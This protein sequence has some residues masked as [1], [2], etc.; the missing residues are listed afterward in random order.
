MT[1]VTETSLAAA[2]AAGGPLLAGQTVILT[3]ASGGIGAA[4]A[5]LLV[6]AGAR[7]A[8]TDL[9]AQPLA[10]LAGELRERTAAAAARTADGDGSAGAEE[11]L[12]AA[13]V[14]A[15]DH[16]AFAA[17]HA[18]TEA[19]LGPVDG[20]VN[21]AGLFEVRS[22]DQLDPAAWSRVVAANLMTAAAGCAAVL[23]G[24]IA[25]G[26]GSVV[27][28]ASTA[29]EYGSISPAAH[30][31]AAKGGVIGLTK[32]LAR[33]AAPAQVRVN[34]VSPGPTETAGLR[35]ATPD[36]RALA[37]SRT[38]FGRLGQPEEIAGACLFLLSP[39]STFVTGHVLR[40]NGGALL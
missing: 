2:L 6:A 10:E 12:F 34:A 40:V 4:I 23:P 33:E 16:A 18:D 22:H 11:R 32:S 5:R 3:G 26:S 37:G 7:V 27:N 19:A 13:A 36:A 1:A 31:A 14:D 25:R 20:I 15:A 29:G 9:H 38:L 8:L 30:Y 35:D 24:M 21:C 39:L 17:F 28:V